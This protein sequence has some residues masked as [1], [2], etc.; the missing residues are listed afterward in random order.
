MDMMWKEERTDDLKADIL[1]VAQ[2]MFKELGYDGT[3]FQKIADVLGITKGAI[4]YH[5]KNKHFIIAYFIEDYFETLRK[6]IDS[7]PEEYCNSYW[8]YCVMYIYA[9]R[10]IMSHEKNYSLFYHKNQMSL[11]ESLKVETV[12]RNYKEI[13]KDFHKTF[14]D[15]ELYMITFM[16]LGARRRLYREFVNA[17]E[18][19]TIDKYAYYHIYLIGFL[20]KLDEMSVKEN[21]QKAFEFADR[22][23][24]PIPAIFDVLDETE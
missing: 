19:L 8:R 6:F 22:H 14:S 17:N 4:T 12:Q 7:F 3:T 1:R 21:I 2:R 13:A 20:A 10:T 24:A 23:S 18:I 9:Y 11:W 16:D 15:E 5:F